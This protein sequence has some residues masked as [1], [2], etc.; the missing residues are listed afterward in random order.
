MI[1]RLCQVAVVLVVLTVA[2]ST[3]AQA[4][5]SRYAYRGGTFSGYNVPRSPVPYT[6]Y[7]GGGYNNVYRGPVW[8]G[9]S[10]YQFHPGG[11]VPHGNHFH[12]IPGHYDLHRGGHWHW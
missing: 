12:Y 10:H 3:T 7:W 2:L 1:R 5:Y 4:Q 8:H 6:T 9:T 11:F